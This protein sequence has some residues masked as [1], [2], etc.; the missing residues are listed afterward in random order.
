MITILSSPKPFENESDWN[1]LNALRSW[2]SIGKNVEI[3][4]FGDVP[5]IKNAVREVGAVHISGIETSSTGAPSFNAM[6]NYA[7]IEGKYDLQIYVNCDILLN[8]NIIK[9]MQISFEKFN[10]FLLVG[11]RLDL[12]E[13]IKID[14]QYPHWEIGLYN[15]VEHAQLKPHGPTGVDYFGFVRGLWGNLPNVYMGRAMCD[16]AL[17][18]YCHKNQIPIIDASQVVTAIHQFHDYSHLDRGKLEVTEGSDKKT[19]AT[20][21]GLKYSLPTISDS[22]FFIDKNGLIINKHQNFFRKIELIL[23]Y[24]Y[25]LPKFSLLFR[26]FQYFNKK[27]IRPFCIPVRMTID[28]WDYFNKN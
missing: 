6:V 11:E 4:V 26:V 16:Q 19:M 20:L 9:S 28:S 21:H 8:F 7:N 1:Q 23:R 15:L 2:R 3:I 5:G 10:K 17:L 22:N 14:T 24:R 12:K 18:H 27:N 25:N 13:K